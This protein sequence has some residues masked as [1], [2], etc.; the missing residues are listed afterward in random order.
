[1]HEK[2]ED[3]ERALECYFVALDICDADLK[4]HRKILRLAHRCQ[5]VSFASDEHDIDGHHEQDEEEE[6]DRENEEEDN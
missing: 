3:M 5:L 4:L 1:M 2:R 6:E